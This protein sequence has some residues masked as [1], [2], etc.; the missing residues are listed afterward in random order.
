LLALLSAG[1]LL[2][3]K[4]AEPTAAPAPGPDRGLGKPAGVHDPSTVV[5]SGDEFWLFATGNGVRSLRS[6]DLQNWQPGPPV[7]SEVPGWVRQIVPGHRGY[8]WAPDVIRAGGRYLLYYSVSTWG[9]NTSA[10]GLATNPTLAPEDL[11]FRWKDEG[12]VARSAAT[13]DFN[14]IDPGLLL[15][16]DGRLWMVFGSFWS[17]IQLVP[18]DAATGRRAAPGLPPQ[19]LAWHEAIE[20]PCLHHRGGHYYLLVNW[21][22]CCRGTNSTYE[23]RVGRSRNVAGPYVDKDGKDLR[24]GGGTLLL[25]TR[26]RLI[27]PGHPGIVTVNG[28]DWM[29]CHFYDRDRRGQPA[30]ALCKLQWSP[31]G[32]PEVDRIQLPER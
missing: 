1:G 20:A 17:G 5:R 26:G 7:L 3:A 32:W 16:A 6:R 30:L 18:L 23:I 31:D 15:D 19:T 10:I 25:G 14:A 4:A 8:F 28:V 24:R 11:A 2:G 21:G 29:S 22:R 9:R 27:G 13:N 12:L